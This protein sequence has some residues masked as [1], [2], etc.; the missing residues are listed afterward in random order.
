MLQVVK[1]SLPTLM[2]GVQ[3]KECLALQKPIQKTPVGVF[4][5]SID[6]SITDS[7]ASPHS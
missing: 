7:R 1:V 4:G 5:G 6:S 2:C 3:S